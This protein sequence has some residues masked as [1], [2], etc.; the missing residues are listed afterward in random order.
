M[1]SKPHSGFDWRKAGLVPALNIPPKDCTNHCSDGPCDCS[2]EW[3]VLAFS[4]ESVQS[5]V[6]QFE[7]LCDKLRLVRDGQVTLHEDQMGTW[8]AG[9]LAL[10][11]SN[12]ASEPDT[13]IAQGY[14]GDQA[15]G[16]Q[17]RLPNPA[18]KPPKKPYVYSGDVD[19]PGPSRSERIQ[20][21]VGKR[22]PWVCTC[23]PGFQGCDGPDCEISNQDT[24]SQ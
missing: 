19:D 18:T 20:A 7:T 14:V 16:P 22:D 23:N 8:A 1:T 3:Q 12:P 11:E 13:I 10:A 24:S 15:V 9:V 2:G 5:L 21:Y 4:F 6:E 17:V